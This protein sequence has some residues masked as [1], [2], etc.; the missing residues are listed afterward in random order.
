MTLEAASYFNFEKVQSMMGEDSILVGYRNSDS[1]YSGMNMAELGEL[2]SHDHFT[3]QGSFVPARPHLLEGLE[4][5]QSLLKKAIDT[6]FRTLID[7]GNKEIDLVGQECLD[8]V[9]EYLDSGILKGI[10]PNAPYTIAKKGHDKPNV[11]QGD[12]EK[13][14]VYI[15]IKGSVTRIEPPQ[16]ILSQSSLPEAT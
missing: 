14:L 16:N 2:L 5:N 15:A 9:R 4:A 13:G 12:L 1:H 10:A 6:Y 7:T 3:P 11:D 8:G